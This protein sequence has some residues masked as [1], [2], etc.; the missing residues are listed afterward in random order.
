MVR[1]TNRELARPIRQG[2]GLRFNLVLT[3]V[4]CYM[5]FCFAPWALR[6]KKHPIISQSERALYRIQTQAI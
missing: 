2:R 5:G 4:I 3:E 1:P 6:E